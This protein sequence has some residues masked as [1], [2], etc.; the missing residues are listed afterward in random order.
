MLKHLKNRHTWVLLCLP[1]IVLVWFLPHTNSVRYGGL[2]ALAL[3]CLTAP[4]IRQRVKAIFGVGAAVGAVGLDPVAADTA[5]PVC[6]VSCRNMA[7][8]ARAVV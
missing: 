2:T 8:A 6:V 4:D 3:L 5:W 7:R 1:L